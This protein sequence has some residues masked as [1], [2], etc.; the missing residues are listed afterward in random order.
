[1]DTAATRSPTDATAYA[2][3]D[4]KCV[5]MV[6]EE[7]RYGGWSGSFSTQETSRMNTCTSTEIFE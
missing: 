3:F 7:K 4:R 1:M 6:A 2:S 5:K